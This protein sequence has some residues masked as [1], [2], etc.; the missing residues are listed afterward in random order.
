MKNVV[1]WD[2]ADHFLLISNAMRGFPTPTSTLLL[3]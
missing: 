2:V 1:K 3:I